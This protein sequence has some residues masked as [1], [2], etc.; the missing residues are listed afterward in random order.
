MES[1]GES[2]LQEAVRLFGLAAKQGLV[3]AQ[4][5]LGYCYYLG[6][7]VHQDYHKA[8]Q[9]FKAAADRGFAGKMEFLIFKLLVCV[10]YV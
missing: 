8:A 1:T 5:M 6:D 9:W 7:G 3:N 10:T 4:V 2:S